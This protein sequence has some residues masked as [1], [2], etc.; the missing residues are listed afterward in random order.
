M[1]IY[2]SKK[3]MFNGNE[4]KVYFWG[5]FETE[6]YVKK[7]LFFKPVNEG[8]GVPPEL[9]DDYLYIKENFHEKFLH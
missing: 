5:F 6:V 4:W 1:T 7:G 8:E 2:H 3:F 9:V